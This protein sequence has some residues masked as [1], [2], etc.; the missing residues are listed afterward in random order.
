METMGEDLELN[1]LLFFFYCTCMKILRLPTI[2][3]TFLTVVY[4]TFYKV[5]VEA[6]L[7]I[8]VFTLSMMY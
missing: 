7:K 3:E 4:F 2:S 8:P 1:C 5:C 6:V